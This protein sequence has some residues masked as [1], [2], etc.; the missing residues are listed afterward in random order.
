MA[1]ARGAR[2]TPL[3]VELATYFPEVDLPTLMRATVHYRSVFDSL[4]FDDWERNGSFMS[5]WRDGVRIAF[6][7]RK[8]Y[9]SIHFRTPEAAELYRSI[10]GSCPSARVTINLPYDESIDV[11]RIH[12]VIRMVLER[13]RESSTGT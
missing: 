5:S 3:H 13:G 11:E 7:P 4:P 2:Y 6:A 9:A 1:A 8:K 12:F 10:G